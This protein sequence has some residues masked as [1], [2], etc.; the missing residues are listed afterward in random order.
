MCEPCV[1]GEAG[2][3][4]GGAGRRRVAFAVAATVGA[5]LVLFYVWCALIVGLDGYR[6]GASCVVPRGY[7]VMDSADLLAGSQS[8]RWFPFP[9]TVCTGAEFA[10]AQWSVFHA[11]GF[12][13]ALIFAGAVGCAVWIRPRFSRG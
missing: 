10:S 9:V 1:V 8:V 13:F 6:A 12:L 11:L 5:F 3:L 4:Q 2:D 7:I